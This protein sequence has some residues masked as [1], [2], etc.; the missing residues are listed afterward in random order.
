MGVDET[1]FDLELIPHFIN[2][3]KSMGIENFLITINAISEDATKRGFEILSG[4]GITP[5]VWVGEFLI[6]TKMQKLIELQKTV[7][8]EW[9]MA[10]D[11][12][13]FVEI[14]NL[15]DLLVRCERGNYPAVRGILIDRV[16]LSKNLEKVVDSIPIGQQFPLRANVLKKFGGMGEKSFLFKYEKFLSTS[17]S[18]NLVSTDGSGILENRYYYPVQFP[19][20]HYKWTST[21]PKRLKTRID[22]FSHYSQITWL[23]EIQG[24]YQYI[25][26]GKFNLEAS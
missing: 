9:T 6:F 4:L 18:H 24:V 14:D 8:T 10:V 21:C 7:K 11:S 2:H 1:L 5:S 13:E 3:Y 16:A 25:K 23:K 22:L 15:L 20:S 17:G 19:I 12:D 26:D